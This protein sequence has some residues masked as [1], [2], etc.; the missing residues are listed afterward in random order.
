VTVRSR[1]LAVTALENLPGCKIGGSFQL[2]PVPYIACA[3]DVKDKE[4]DLPW[5]DLEWSA[6]VVVVEDTLKFVVLE[7][8]DKSEFN[9][10]GALSFWPSFPHYYAAFSRSIEGNDPWM[11]YLLFG[12]SHEFSRGEILL[13]PVMNMEYYLFNI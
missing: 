9:F 8:D 6:K 10:S 1:R 12:L 3:S 5:P 13:E 11:H 4:R 7:L 2:R